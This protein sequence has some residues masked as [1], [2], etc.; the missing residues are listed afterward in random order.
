MSLEDIMHA[1]FSLDA[2]PDVVVCKAV[3]RSSGHEAIETSPGFFRVATPGEWPEVKKARLAELDS[4][5]A[6]LRK[7]LEEM[8]KPCTQ[9]G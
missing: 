8:D 4:R 5:V 2:L 9:Q 6:S 3:L 7:M 1:D